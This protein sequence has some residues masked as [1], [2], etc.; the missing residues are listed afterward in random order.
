MDVI[1]ARER[2]A[3]EA[4]KPRTQDGRPMSLREQLL[5]RIASRGRR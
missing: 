4:A 1:A 5:E 2:R 3:A